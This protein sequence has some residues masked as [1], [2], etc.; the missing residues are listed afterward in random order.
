MIRGEKAVKPIRVVQYG[1]GPIGIASAQA[2]LEKSRFELVGAVDIDPAKAGRDL[3]EV[4]GIRKRLG[5]RVDTDARVLLRRT[6]AQVVVHT[7]R[8]RFK[9][10][11]PQ[12]DQIVREGVSVV[13]ST[14]ELLFPRLKNPGLS[15]KLDRLAGKHGATIVGT[16][17]N[18]GFVMDTL[19]LVLTGVCRE[20]RSLRIRRRVDAST[21]RMPLQRKVGAGLSQA[22]FRKLVRGHK[23]GHVGLVESMALIASGLGWN[24]DRVTEK[25][26]PVVAEERLK[27]Q[28]FLVEAGQ[29][30]GLKHTGAG[31][32]S[33]RRVIDMDLRM[34]LGAKDPH[35]S[36]DI[37][38]N[39]ELHL[40]LPG[41]VAGDV[42]TVA[43]LVNAIPRVLEAGPGLKTLLDLTLP[44]AVCAL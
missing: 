40:V 32:R 23:L 13:S 37:L 18:P 30:C 36:I 27:T 20:V 16:G 9:E 43:S 15:S 10:V 26:E 3:G 34:Y 14:E 4:L 29:V 24:L 17:V 11:Y 44:R 42:A 38:G 33:G 31:Y 41:G 8:S 2:L 7:T 5:L 21:R 6:R 12:L 25:I 39:P 1:L 35:D 19:A 22:E 28:Y